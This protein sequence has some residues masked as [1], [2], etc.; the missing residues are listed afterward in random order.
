MIN[1]YILAKFS[2]KHKW[3]FVVFSLCLRKQIS[4]WK[5]YCQTGKLHTYQGLELQLYE[6]TGGVMSFSIP[7]RCIMQNHK[8]YLCVLHM[9]SFLHLQMLHKMVENN[10][11]WLWCKTYKK[12]KSIVAKD[13]VSLMDRVPLSPNTQHS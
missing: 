6:L 11:N 10:V 7:T 1:S 8:W 9:E 5:W 3:G 12:E 4:V 2:I 13:I